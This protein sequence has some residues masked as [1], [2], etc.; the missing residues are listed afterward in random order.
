MPVIERKRKID[1]VATAKP[2][3]GYDFKMFEDVDG[4]RK[5][6][7]DGLSCCD[8]M[9]DN[10]RVPHWATIAIWHVVHRASS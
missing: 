10:R 3:G 5:E 2:G 7:T 6:R 9:V 8:R 1:V 4:I